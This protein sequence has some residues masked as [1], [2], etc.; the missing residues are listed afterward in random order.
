MS[1]NTVVIK[2]A[3][4]MFFALCA[5]VTA[6]AAT[7]SVTYTY[8]VTATGD[9]TNPPL[10]GNGTGA[11]VPLGNMTWR[12]VAFVNLATGAVTGTFSATFAN[13]TLFGNL[14]EQADL[15]APPTAV[16]ISQTLEVTGGTGAFLWYNGRLMGGGIANLVSGEPSTNTGAGTLTTTPEPRSLVLLPTG[17]L[18]FLAYRWR[19]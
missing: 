15:S 4:F 5:V 3:G 2:N 16:P 11:I 19:R 13:G 10:I 14:F 1:V 6:P 7:I 8:N 12:D 9:P 17:L 18:C